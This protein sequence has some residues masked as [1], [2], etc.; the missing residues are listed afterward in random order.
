M[1][2]GKIKEFDYRKIKEETMNIIISEETTPDFL[3]GFCYAFKFLKL[4]DD[5]QFQSI[6][7]WA[8][9]ICEVYNKCDLQPSPDKDIKNK[10]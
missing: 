6:Q 5:H 4:I 1:E 8:H 2:K 3:N 10:L 7:P 9:E